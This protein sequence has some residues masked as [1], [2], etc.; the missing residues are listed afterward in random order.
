MSSKSSDIDILDCYN[1]LNIFTAQVENFLGKPYKN[2]YYI[3]KII[4]KNLKDPRLEAIRTE[5]LKPV[6]I[7]YKAGTFSLDRKYGWFEGNIDWLGSSQRVLLDKDE[8]FPH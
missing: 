1:R 4:R 3:V 7:E 2:R 6:S 8:K 5:Y